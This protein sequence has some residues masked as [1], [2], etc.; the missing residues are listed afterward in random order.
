M[1][2]KQSSLNLSTFLFFLFF[3]FFF[4][5]CNRKVSEFIKFRV[6]FKSSFSTEFSVEFSFSRIFLAE[7]QK[8]IFIYFYFLGG[9]I[10]EA[11]D[12][13]NQL[14]IFLAF[15]VPFPK[16]VLRVQLVVPDKNEEVTFRCRTVWDYCSLFHS[17]QI[18][19]RT[20]SAWLFFLEINSYIFGWFVLRHINI[21]ES[22]NAELIYFDKSSK[23]SVS[24]K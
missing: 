12:E 4:F 21:L 17:G 14:A 19:S 9:F 7:L 20:W 13:T 11:S 5:L 22:F 1:S 23:N 2:G 24:C 10:Q 15:T 18:K 16:F 3:L 6:F 8:S